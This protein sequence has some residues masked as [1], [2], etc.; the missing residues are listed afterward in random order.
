MELDRN[1][2]DIDASDPRVI[3][4]EGK[5]YLTTLS[6]F[7]LAYSI[8]GKNF[9]VTDKYIIGHGELE[10]Y[11][12]EDCR[13]TQLEDT[14]FLTYTA[15]SECGYGVNMTSTT[16]W[17]NFDRY[18]M[19]ISGP[20]KDC[21]IFQEKI[22]GKYFCLHR[23]TMGKLGGNHIWLADSD[24][25]VHWGNHKCIAKTRPGMWDN[26]RI[27]AGA[28]P[29]KTEKGWLEIYHSADDNSRYC[30]GAI[31]LDLNDPS[32]VIARSK[33]PIMQPVMDYEKK[34]FFGNV[35]FTNGHIVNGDSIWLYYG[36][37]DTVICGAELSISQILASL[38]I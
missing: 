16:D 12:I 22:G 8:D 29:I 10:A 37:S 27:G 14:Y 3:I 1:I 32:K 21:A 9:K 31:L 24:D 34:G 30:L 13:V 33:E 19:I 4:Y 36:A 20:N 15:V 25:L 2:P 18:G 28:A 35:I 11:G 7:R 23:P 38:S 5:A 6:H 17:E 26:E